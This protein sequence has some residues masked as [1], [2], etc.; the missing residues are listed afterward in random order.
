MIDPALLDDP[1]LTMALPPGV[2]AYLRSAKGVKARNALLDEYRKAS[3]PPGFEPLLKAMIERTR[4]TFKIMLQEHVP[5]I[6]G[7]DTPGVDGFLQQL[8]GGGERQLAH[9]QIVDDEQGH[10]HQELHLFFACAVEC[11]FCEFI[12][13]GVGFT[14]EHAVALMDGCVPDGLGQVTLAG[15]WISFS[16]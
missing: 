7:S 13:Q 8:F 5:L 15:D 4:A 12:E 16:Y 3:P 1:R 6:F 2:I 11:C 9:A 14:V 10:C